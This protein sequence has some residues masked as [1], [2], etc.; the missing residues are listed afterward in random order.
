MNTAL[1]MVG[2]SSAT[3]LD[4]R[5]K[6]IGGSDI[7][8][9]LGLSPYKTPLDLWMEK[10]GLWVD[11]HRSEAAHW[12]SIME[13]V[14]AREYSRRHQITLIR[15]EPELGEV[16]I[17]PDYEIIQNPEE[18]NEILGTLQHPD[19]PWARGHVDGVGVNDRGYSHICEFK[20]ADLRLGSHWGD[21]DTDQIPDA[22][23]TQ[24]QWYLML[25]ELEVA[26][27]AA[28]IG[29]NRFRRYIVQRDDDLIELMLE[30]AAEF[31]DRV[32]NEN[33]PEA[34]P[35]E[36]G[37]ESLSRLYKV[38]AKGK[39]IDATP[40]LLKLSI[41]L[42]AMREAIKSAEKS[43]VSVEN[44]IKAVMMDAAR[45]NLGPSSYISWQNNKD[46]EVIDWEAVARQIQGDL[47]PEDESVFRAAVA[48]HTTTK[49]G[50]RVFRVQG[51]DKL[52]A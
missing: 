6:G 49:P 33:P 21:P 40:E 30:R 51:L 50:P 44:E 14:L 22:Y 27:V 1:A 3:N 12:G 24:V 9:L 26:H 7:A 18:P 52:S 19:H 29:G 4:E 48:A 20:T 47:R 37:K 28:L 34:E 35:G 15:R 25:S 17:A 42:H 38:G 8:P 45:L 5:S 11:E 13:P 23:L 36:R 41:D 43:K 10:V 39:E 31:W 16:V 46:S 32:V 2:A